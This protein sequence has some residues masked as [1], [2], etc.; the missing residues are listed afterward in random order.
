[1]DKNIII[2]VY[3]THKK[4]GQWNKQ[5]QKNNFEYIKPWHKSITEKNLQGVLLVDN[6]CGQDFINKYQ[7]NN[8]KMIK[9]QPTK[10]KH[11]LHVVRFLDIY[12]YLQSNIYDNVLL[13]DV[14]DVMFLKNPFD[15]I[16]DDKKLYVGCEQRHKN[17]DFKIAERDPWAKHNFKRFYNA[18]N[19]NYPFWKKKFLNCGIV[20]GHYH[21]VMKFL[22]KFKEEASVPPKGTFPMDMPIMNYVCYDNF[23]E[24]LITGQPLHT[25]FGIYDVNNKECYIAHK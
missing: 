7:N 2:G 5:I 1:M 16:K 20:G 15:F 17:G 23:S 13:T 19:K 14:S 8:V 12:K 4:D 18:K 21:N 11:A 25:I 6:S 10:S 22:N 24:N 3:Y 9:I